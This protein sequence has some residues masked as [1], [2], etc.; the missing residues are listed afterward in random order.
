MEEIPASE[1]SLFLYFI[2][3]GLLPNNNNINNNSSS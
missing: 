3:N 1:T 2:D